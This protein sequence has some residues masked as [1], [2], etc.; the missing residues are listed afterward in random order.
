MPNPTNYAVKKRHPFEIIAVCVL[1]ERLHVLVRL[2]EKDSGCPACLRLI[3][4]KFPQAL[5]ETENL[6]ALR[7][8]KNE[9]GICQRRYW[10][11]EIRDEHDLNSHIDYIH[12]NPVKHG[13]VTRAAD[14]PYSS[15]HRYAA[16]GILPIDWAGKG[17]EIEGNFG[18]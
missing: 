13:Y 6:S 12:I 7:Q 1:P 14:W 2:P 17:T 9:H 3:T 18:E 4:A 8:S 11:H 5:P 10:E 16:N 15:F